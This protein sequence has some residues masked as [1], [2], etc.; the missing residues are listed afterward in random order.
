MS[1]Y[2][3]EIAALATAFCWSITSVSFESAGKKLGTLNLNLI[4][5]VLG[6]IFL[7]IYTFFTRGFL[8]PLDASFETWKWL[9]LSGLVGVVLGA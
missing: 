8:L 3:G 2:I 6:M 5:L 7:S 4:R 9:L 1:N